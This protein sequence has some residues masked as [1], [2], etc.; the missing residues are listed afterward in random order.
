[1]F[2]Q[3]GTR[4]LNHPIRV[5]AVV[6]IL[7]LSIVSGAMYVVLKT[8]NDTFVDTDTKAYQDTEDFAKTYGDAPIIVMFDAS[9]DDEAVNMETMETMDKLEEEVGTDDNVHSITSLNTVLK[10]MSERQ[11]STYLEALKEMENTLEDS[12]EGLDEFSGM[13]SEMEEDLDPAMMASIEETLEELATSQESL[14]EGLG[15]TANSLESTAE[16]LFELSEEMEAKAESDDDQ[17]LFEH[18]E[19]LEESAMRLAEVPNTLED[20]AGVAKDTEEGVSELD[21]SLKSELDAMVSKLGS[22]NDASVKLSEMSDGFKAMADRLSD[23]HS[24][25]DLFRSGLP[26][27]KATLESM[28]HDDEGN[29]RRAFESVMVDDQY[30]LMTIRVQGTDEAAT[31]AII[32]TVDAFLDG[33][34]YSGETLLSGKPVLDA[35][36]KNSMQESLPVLIALALGTMLAILLVAFHVRWRILPLLITVFAVVIT[37]GAIGYLKVPITMVSMAVFPILIGLGIDYSIEFQ[38]RYTEI[39]KEGADHE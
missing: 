17:T 21:E 6:V 27:D 30:A 24:R 20:Y 7:G 15:E 11:R 37:I 23:M 18:A 19:T 36:I 5:V 29:P 25:A 13:F 35:S 12:A 22:L 33:S 31:K 3:L 14:D 34:D 2:K 10:T 1:M 39:L 28:V 16:S 26:Q 9:S 32:D 4:I 38:N 8:G